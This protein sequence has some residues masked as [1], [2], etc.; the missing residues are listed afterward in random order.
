MRPD[1]STRTA[2]RRKRC[3][4]ATASLLTVLVLL[5]ATDAHAEG[6]LVVGV[7]H[8]PIVVTDLERAAA[9]FHSMGFAIKPGRYH[10]DGIRN[11]HIK[12]PDGTE[13]ELITAPEAVDPLTA[14]YFAK[15]QRGEGPLYF[16]LKAPDHVALAARLRALGAPVQQEGG[17]LTFPVGTPLHPLFFGWGEKAPD[18]RPEHYA[19]ANSAMR[20]SGF[21][22]RANSQE[23]ALFAGLGLPIHRIEPCGPLGMADDVALPR[24]DLFLVNEGLEDGAAIGARIE[25]RSLDVAAVT[26]KHNGFRPL[27]YPNCRALWL[28]PSAGHGLWLE[29]VQ[30]G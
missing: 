14:E 12:F 10:T 23:R 28:P 2:G 18:D 20:V 29:F 19:H 4:G 7:D 21:W 6:A 8:T 5:A 9:D 3:L 24:G 26:L 27:R 16:G 1:P 15:E 13:L 11:A 22:L 17:L 25:V 30:A